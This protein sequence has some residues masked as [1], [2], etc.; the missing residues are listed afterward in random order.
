MN[1]VISLLSLHGFMAWTETHLPSLF[2][3]R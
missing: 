1:E 3:E 2:A